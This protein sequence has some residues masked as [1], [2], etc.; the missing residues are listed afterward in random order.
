VSDSI[1]RTVRIGQLPQGIPTIDMHGHF[2]NLENFYIPENTAE[3]MIKA[4]DRIGIYQTWISSLPALV[5]DMRGG[6]REVAVAVRS[7]PKR[8]KGYAV[9]NPNF[10]EQSTGELKRCYQEY[11]FRG[12]K[13]H[14]YF[15]ESSVGGPGYE[16]VWKF[17][18]EKKIHVLAHVLPQDMPHVERILKNYPDLIMI[19]A[20][21]NQPEFEPC[22]NAV[23]SHPN[24]Y[25]DMVSSSFPYGIV[26]RL[27]KTVG[28]EKVLFGTDMPYIDPYSQYGKIAFAR[29]DDRTKENI[30]FRN[31]QRLLKKLR[32]D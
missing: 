21:I 6:N 26:E 27:V 22:M 10:A 31:A 7:Y 28:S 1:Y 29:L 2:G 15:H 23:S 18:S 4:M 11:G 12:I 13:I 9:F 25:C 8:F 30:F 3:K 5:A 14:C 20:H 17:A 19:I 16:P 24:L 32:N